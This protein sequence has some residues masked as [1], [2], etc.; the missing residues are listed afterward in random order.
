MSKQLKPVPVWAWKDYA[1]DWIAI[2]TVTVRRTPNAW[3]VFTDPTK[4]KKR[5]KV[6]R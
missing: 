4:P 5:K 1:G 3:L 6:K 2:Q